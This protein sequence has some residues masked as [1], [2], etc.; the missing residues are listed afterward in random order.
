MADKLQKLVADKKDVVE[1]VMEVFEQG[2]EVVASIAGDL[3]PVFSIAAPI[4]KLALDNV[5]SKEAEYMKEQF[6]RVRER[7]EVVSEEIQ[8]INEEVK[9]SG[10]DAAYFSVE[11]NLTNL[12]RKYMDILNAKPKFREAKK[13]QFMEHF[14]KT[15]G[16][17]NLHTLYSA[18]T[19]DN[20]SGESVL[21]ITLN[22]EQKS[23]R[24]VE[25]FC[26]RLKQ[27]FCIGLIALMGHAALKGSEDEEQLLKEWAEKMKVVQEKMIIVIEDCIN[28]FPSQAEI[29]IKRLVRDNRDKTNQQLADMILEA[30]KKKYDWIGWSVRVFNSPTGLFTSK[31]DYHCPTGK[32]RFQVPTSDEKLNVFVSYSASPEP[33]DKTQIQQW[34]EAQKKPSVTEV[35][36][37]L[38]EKVPV[39]V[40][41]TV[42]T[43]CKEMAYAWSFKDELHFFE[44]Y[45]NFYLFVHSA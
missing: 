30:L 38:F 43:S 21:E 8:R 18:V 32:S 35:A 10:A 4:V 9:K 39:C 7:L 14:S 2:A 5:E 29:D 31:K 22:Y 42:K 11:E 19:G 41:H 16:D 33:L 45:K 40:V 17:K 25:D 13:K 44:Q 15:G 20:F 37:I 26:A 28:S 3:F 12:F 36:E 23:R 1:T 34:V 24:A 6:Q 27:L